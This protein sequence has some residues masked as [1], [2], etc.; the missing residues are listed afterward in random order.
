MTIG[1]ISSC[2]AI[3][4]LASALAV[5]QTAAAGK[6]VRTLITPTP[7]VVSDV[8]A[9]DVGVVP[10]GKDQ[11]LTTF[12]SGRTVVHTNSSPTLTNLVSGKSL[13]YRLRYIATA[14]PAGIVGSLSGQFNFLL[15]PGDVG[16]S[17]VVPDGAFLHIVGHLRYTLDP[18]TF[19]VTSFSVRGT[20]TDIC[21][22]LAR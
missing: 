4:A 1:R 11:V 21:A 5:A 19:A 2:A 22:D 10:N 17:G 15:F 3:V 16:P 9:F 6:P 20:V 14:D 18:E 8:C 13:V 7:F 12:D